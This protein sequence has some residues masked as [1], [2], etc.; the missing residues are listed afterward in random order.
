M[1]NRIITA[2]SLFLNKII[3]IITNGDTIIYIDE[4]SF[5]NS[6]VKFK[7]W[8]H[9]LD[10]KKTYY[11]G[12]MKSVN[13]VLA[14]TARK[15]V[16]YQAK[17][18]TLDSDGMEDFINQLLEKTKEDKDLN[19][20]YN[21]NSLW[22]YFDNARVHKSKKVKKYLESTNFSVIYGAA[23]HPQYDMAEFVFGFLKARFYR[24]ICTTSDQIIELIKKALIDLDEKK[25]FNYYLHTL[26]QYES[27]SYEINNNINK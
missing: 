13:L 1:L 11:P 9:R 10:S 6:T 3:S 17:A 8:K 15:V 7:C 5:N 19:K 16:H 12:R 21:N 14:V 4:S 27:D 22:L 23:Y 2:K 26:N 25:I 20:A 24:N 18:E